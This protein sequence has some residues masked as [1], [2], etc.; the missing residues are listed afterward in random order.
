M[1]KI[2]NADKLKKLKEKY[3]ENVMCTNGLFHLIDDN[4][5]YEIYIN[6]KTE[7]ADN[8]GKYRT[9]AV[10][11]SIIVSEILTDKKIRFVIFDKNTLEIIF[12]TSG[13]M[14]YVDNNL[15]YCREGNKF[16]LISH[17]GKQLTELE[18][19]GKIEHIHYCNYLL[20]NKKMFSDHIIFYDRFKDRI[21]TLT[22]DKKYSI[23]PVVDGSKEIEVVSM[24]GGKYHYN[25][26]TKACFNCFTNKEEKSTYLW[27]II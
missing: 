6:P 16:I 19:V 10:M 9:I 23:H 4:D 17:T 3:G 27:K 12:K 20:N 2:S 21:I 11:D 24:Q 14:R 5:H 18:D 13:M 15:I 25:F 1:D 22:E 7:K 8:R 26:E